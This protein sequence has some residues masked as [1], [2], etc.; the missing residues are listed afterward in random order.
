MAKIDFLSIVEDDLEVRHQLLR[1]QAN[2]ILESYNQ[3]WDVLSELFQNAVDAIDQNT[4]IPKGRIEFGFDIQNHQISIRDNGTGI[5]KDQLA[6][7][8]RPSVSLKDGQSRLRG[9]KGVGL[10]FLMFST[11]HFLVESL[12]DGKKVRGVITNAFDWVTKRTDEVPQLDLLEEADEELGSYTKFVLS[13]VSSIQ[14]GLEIFASSFGRLKHII[15]TRTAA[16]HTGVLF[17]S[18]PEKEIDIELRYRDENGEESIESIPYAYD[19][20]QNYIKPNLTFARRKE[21]LGEMKEGQAKGKAVY[22]SGDFITTSGKEIKYFYFVCSR[23]KFAEMSKAI[24]GAEDRELVR[25]G[26]Y[27]STKNM[28]TGVMVSPPSIGKEGYWSNLFIVFEYDDLRLDMGRKS[29]PPRTSQMIKSQAEKIYNEIKNHFGDILDTDFEIEEE[30][31]ASQEIDRMWDHLLSNTNNLNIPYLS[32]HKEPEQEQGVVAIFYELVGC[33]KLKGYE[34]W[35]NS[36]RDTYDAFIKYRKENREDLH[37]VI[38]EFKY[39]GSDVIEDILDNRKEY[40]KI[41]LLVCWDIDKSKFTQKGF[42]IREFDSEDNRF[43]HGSTH[44]IRIPSIGNPLEA[45]VLRSFLVQNT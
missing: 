25:G 34:T 38:V 13:G 8:L 32:Y 15:R 20:P 21:L 17:G 33:G 5:N 23:S 12:S 16:G 27:L 44:E 30:L 24:Q 22:S 36:S 2:N 18:S 26:I 45:I 43:F 9:E 3:D 41:K 42:S 31:L 35:R 7:I 1:K 28:P 37:K 10:S 40:S 4:Q 6:H 14:E 39:E 29:V 11:N 19:G